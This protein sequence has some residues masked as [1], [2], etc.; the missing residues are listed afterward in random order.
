MKKIVLVLLIGLLAGTAAFAD[1]DG[2]GIGLLVG[3]GGGAHGG[4]FYPGL[5][6]KVPH[7]PVFWGFYTQINP[8]YFGINITGDYYIIDKNIFTNTV[9][10]EDGDYKF[11]LDWFL[12]VG[13]AVNLNFWRWGGFGFGLGGRFPVGLSWHV[14]TPF[15]IAL[16]FT[17]TFGTYFHDTYWGFWWDLD[18][19]LTFRYWFK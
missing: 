18:V 1:H 3:G 9:S 5:S 2:F 8:Y 12:G 14:V 4:G 10:N 15:E 7:V 6:L 11:K 17:P 13:G 16:G 19:E